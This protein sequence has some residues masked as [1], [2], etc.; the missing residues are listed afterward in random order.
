[1]RLVANK[2]YRVPHSA[3]LSR[4]VSSYEFDDYFALLDYTATAP[5]TSPSQVLTLGCGRSRDM[6]W[7]HTCCLGVMGGFHDSGSHDFPI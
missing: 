7:A 5:H 2:S 1:M 3:N 4:R 6:A